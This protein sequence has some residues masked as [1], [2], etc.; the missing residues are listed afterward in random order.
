MAE[1]DEWRS[2]P[3]IM[4]ID[5]AGRG[6]VL[7]PMVYAAAYCPAALMGTLAARCARGILLS[8]QHPDVGT[9]NPLVAVSL[10]SNHRKRSSLELRKRSC[11]FPQGVCK[12]GFLFPAEHSRTRRH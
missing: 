8:R 9:G 4:G 10:T 11:N 3:C 2:Q 12:L 7:G 1:A 5:E 6:P